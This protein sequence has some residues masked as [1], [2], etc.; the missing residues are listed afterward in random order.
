MEFLPLRRLSPSES[1]SRRLATPTTF[2]PQGFSP[3]R[4]FAPRPNARP[5]FMP[6][7]PMGF[8]LQGFSP[9]VRSR[10]LV[11]GEI[12]LL[13]FFLRNAEQAPHCGGTRLSANPAKDLRHEPLTTFR[14]FAP[15]VDPYRCWT[16]TSR[17]AAD[18]LLSFL[19]LSRVLPAPPGHAARHVSR[20]CALTHP[21]QTA[22][23]G[24]SPE[25]DLG[26]SGCASAD[27][28]E[29]AGFHSEKRNIPS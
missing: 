2:R 5:C 3:S 12:T 7:T 10:Q 16:V 11:A 20:S 23:P 24:T 4:R 21:L 19:H 14:V 18:P 25:I 27:S 22:Y 13:V 26:F 29:N 9:T 17:T 6:V 1:T 28:P 8:A 15:T